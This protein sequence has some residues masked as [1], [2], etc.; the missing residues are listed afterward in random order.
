MR[1]GISPPESYRIAAFDY[2]TG[3]PKWQVNEGIFGLAE[4]L[5]RIRLS[6]AGWSSCQRS[7]DR[8][9]VKRMAVYRGDGSVKWRKD[10]LRQYLW[11]HVFC[12]TTGLS[13]I[14]TLTRIRLVH[15]FCTMAVKKWYRIQS[16]VSLNLGT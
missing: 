2:E 13:P 8:R 15:S 7:I 6:A 4:L 5:R 1:R 12:I 14:R 9:S 11:V 10:D 16:P 3:E